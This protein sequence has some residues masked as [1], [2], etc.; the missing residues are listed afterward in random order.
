MIFFS[1][2]GDLAVSLNLNPLYLMLPAAVIIINHDYGGADDDDDYAD[3][4]DDDYR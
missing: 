3:A 2:L 1:V 4:G